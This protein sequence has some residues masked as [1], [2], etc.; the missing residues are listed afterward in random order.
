MRKTGDSTRSAKTWLSNQLLRGFCALLLSGNASIWAGPAA[1][2]QRFDT[3]A[4]THTGTI[5]H[6]G[7]LPV[8]LAARDA[9][10]YRIIFT[11]QE[12]GR[13]ADA[14]REIGALRDPIL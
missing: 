10:R 5:A 11:L 14:D 4:L 2:E 13:W 6:D 9:M 12:A 3:A 7:E 1:S 8:V